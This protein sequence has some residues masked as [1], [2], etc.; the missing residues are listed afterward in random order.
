MPTSD[1]ETHTAG[2]Y[3]RKAGRRTATK[4]ATKHAYPDDS[5]T[6]REHSAS[7]E[8]PQHGRQTRRNVGRELL[9]SFC[10]V[11]VVLYLC[12]EAIKIYL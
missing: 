12:D 8:Q 4:T 5:T 6:D 11:V 7:S 9:H 10:N 2:T 1:R 3:V